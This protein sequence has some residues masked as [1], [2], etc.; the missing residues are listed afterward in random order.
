M[1][2]PRVILPDCPACKQPGL[3]VIES[4]KTGLSTRRRKGCECC[5]HR[6]TTHEVSA[7]F[8]EQAKQNQW[9]VEQLQSL[10]GNSSA[11][12]QLP[13]IVTAESK[14]SD[15]VHNQNDLCV[16]GFPEYDTDESFDCNHFES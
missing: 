16:F 5:G 7:D 9:L 2:F 15:C 6:F 3:R 14:C 8:F 10:L 4:R 11:T 1:A 13:P 12:T